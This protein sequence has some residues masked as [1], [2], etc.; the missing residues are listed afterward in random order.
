MQPGSAAHGG[1]V[2]RFRL[3]ILVLLVAS[4]IFLPLVASPPHL[5]DDVDAVQAQIARNML[6]S[7]D[8]VTARLDGVPYLEKS[9]LIYWIMAASFKVLGVHDW[10]ARLPLALINIALCW[11]T[12]RFAGWAFDKRAGIYAGA[13]LATCVGMFLFTRILI[14]DAALTLT[15]TLALWAFLR[16]EDGSE[17]ARWRWFF[18]LYFSLGCGL[19]LKGLIAAVFPLGIIAVYLVVTRQLESRE[20]LRNLRPFRGLLLVLLVAAPWHVIAALRNPPLFDWTMR[21]VP[22]EY[23]GFF[24]FY[25][26]NEHVFRFLNMRYPRDYNT[27]PRAWFWL[28]H[29]AWLFPWSATLLTAFHRDYRPLGRAGKTRLL[30]LIWIGFVLLFF[31]LSTTQEYYSLPIYPALAML[32]GSDLAVRERY[33]RAAR[34]VL[35]SLFVASLAAIILLLL[36]TAKYPAPGDISSALSQNPS[37]YTLSLG[38]MGDLTLRSFAYLR[39]P[40]GLAGCALLIG[41]FGLARPRKTAAV[42]AVLVVVMVVFVQAARLA[43]I[44]FDPYLG[45]RPL[46]DALLRSQPG[47]LIEGDAYYAFSSVFFY[48]GRK[49]L[50][51]NGRN[52]NLEYGSYAPGAPQVFIDDEKLK[53]LW[54]GEQRAYLLVYGA[55]L[56]RLNT[57]L[58]SRYRVVASSGGNYLLSNLAPAAS[59]THQQR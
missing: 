40:L 8:W 44:A 42:A 19:L 3:D 46:A 58:D 32:V 13:V 51:W 56:P 37:L 15:I 4:C 49:A 1:I 5:M 18:L 16:L 14:P 22:G 28:L 55:E 38:H 33:P 29:F 35:M 36:R 50:L 39:A 9:P 26:L 48:T 10:S 53:T 2:H 21:S 52:N 11:V 59:L 45:S 25:F 6:E 43:L 41:V 57:L 31:T 27:V 30:A 47:V 20:L 24:W 34:V 54:Q 17:T 23:H 12:A 7:G